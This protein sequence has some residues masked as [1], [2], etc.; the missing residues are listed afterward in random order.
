MGSEMCIR[1][2]DYSVLSVQFP[3]SSGPVTMCYLEKTE[4]LLPA[5]LGVRSLRHDPLQGVRAINPR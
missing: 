4:V 3:D 5:L 1:D 2:S